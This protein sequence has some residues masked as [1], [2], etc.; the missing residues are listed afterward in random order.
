MTP[1]IPVCLSCVTR[2]DKP[3]VLPKPGWG[4]PMDGPWRADGTKPPVT[5]TC[6]R[7]GCQTIVGLYLR[8]PV[9]SV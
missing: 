8:P 1:G 5:E 4:G 3:N 6:S 7:C 9:K 2:E